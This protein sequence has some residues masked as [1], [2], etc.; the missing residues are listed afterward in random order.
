MIHQE[1]KIVRT[2]CVRAPTE[3]PSPVGGSD[4]IDG[5]ILDLSLLLARELTRY[6]VVIAVAGDL[7]AVGDDRFH[8]I[9]I[10]LGDCAAGKEA[11]LDALF[12]ENAQ[13]APN[14]GVRPVLALGIFLVVERAVF[15]RPHILAP[16]EVEGQTHRHTGLVGPREA[17]F[18]MIF[19]KHS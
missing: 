15:K 5:L 13:N 14:R 9:R 7:V 11:S 3:G 4:Y 16:L 6:L 10:T 12:V 8:R 19:L 1:L 17:P 2:L 18:V